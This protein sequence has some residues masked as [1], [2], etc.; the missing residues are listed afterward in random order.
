MAKTNVPG[1]DQLEYIAVPLPSDVAYP[2]VN[3][4]AG[5]NTTLH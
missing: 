1:D 2:N 4:V 3:V 5:D